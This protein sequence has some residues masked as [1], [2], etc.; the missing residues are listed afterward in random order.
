[1]AKLVFLGGTAA[2]N[3]WRHG[4]MNRLVGRGVEL[5]QLFNPVVKDWN[6]AAQAKEEAAKRDASYQ[7]YYLAAPMQDGNPLS[8]YS[9]VEATMAL[10]DKP[11]T[12]VIVFDTS[13]MEG[14]ALKAMKQT[15]KVLRVRHPNAKIFGTS[16][17]AEDWLV[18]QLTGGIFTRLFA[19]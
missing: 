17:D 2:N 18:G 15:E 6:A 12:T 19:A 3:E 1:M 14:H 16:K 7:I 4:F 10:Y 11:K 8:A 13:G 9:M 5:K